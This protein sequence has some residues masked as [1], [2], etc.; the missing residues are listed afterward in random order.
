M[1]ATRKL[2]DGL[3]E[4]YPQSSDYLAPNSNIVHSPVF[5]SAVCKVQGKL[6]NLLSQSEKNSLKRFL[7]IPLPNNASNQLDADDDDDAELSFAERITNNIRAEKR[8]RTDV[9][10]YKSLKHVC[11]DSNIVERLFSRA[12]LIMRDHRK[13][14]SPYHLEMLL[15]LRCNSGM[16]NVQT[17]DNIIKENKVIEAPTPTTEGS[18]SDSDEI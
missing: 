2:F 12:K 4:I 10:K 8:Q 3:I 18:D 9:S 7:K 15:M 6:E 5:E 13:H 17:I 14:M 1:Y 11:K 16:W